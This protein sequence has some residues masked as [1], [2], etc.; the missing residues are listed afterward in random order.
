[1]CAF[2]MH[3]FQLKLRNKKFDF[4]VVPCMK[5][6]HFGWR[7]EVFA[8]WLGEESVGVM[9]ARSVREFNGWRCWWRWHG[10]VHV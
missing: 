2:V 4:L 6:M 7:L 8:F 5:P 1:M 10:T 3:L 9:V